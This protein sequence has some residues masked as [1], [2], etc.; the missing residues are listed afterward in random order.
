MFKTI[1]KIFVVFAVLLVLPC[2][3]AMASSKVDE[4]DYLGVEEL[5]KNVPESA[6]SMLEGVDIDESLD[7]GGAI[8]NILGKAVGQIG[9]IL[10]STASGA[11][12]V[13]AAT[14][15]CSIASGIYSQSSKM[16]DAINL[17]GVVVIAVSS[18]SGID[19]LISVASETINE[20]GA[21]SKILL[22]VLA[23]ASAITGSAASS[24]AKYAAS[25]LFIDLLMTIGERIV[26]PLIYMYVGVSVASAA[27]GGNIGGIAKLIAKTVKLILTAIAIAFTIYLTVT[28][29]V[30]S[31][32]DA[33]TVK[34]TKTAISTFLP[35]VGSLISDAADA[36]A[37]GVSV[38]KSAAGA[39]G[40]LVVCAVCAVPFL[41]LA[42]SCLMYRAAAALAEP[43]ADSRLSGLIESISN[44]CGMAL[45]L[46]GTSAVMLLIS[47]ISVTKAV[48]GL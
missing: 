5:E 26:L 13:L 6:S 33:A 45:G 12:G 16:S 30:A 3:Y 31:S 32:A 35:V 8:G 15:L 20:T 2:S 43:V 48:T 24:A 14:A 46:A 29:L 7:A 37:S 17:V 28:G 10:R 11:V 39:F 18:I 42:I 23:S 38:V 21:F 4:D 41:R 27:F 19:S 9:E 34:V 25:I 47:I 44:A 22:P 36:V 1:L 40:V